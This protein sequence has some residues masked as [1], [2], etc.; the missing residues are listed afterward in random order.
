[1]KKYDHFL[2]PTQ[3]K[4]YDYT[5]GAIMAVLPIEMKLYA[6]VAEVSSILAKSIRLHP[7]RS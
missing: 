4:F 2:V 5:N 6:G 1:M 7:I 3:V